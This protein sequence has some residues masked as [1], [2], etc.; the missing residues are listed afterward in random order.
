LSY[1]SSITMLSNIQ[2]K[3]SYNLINKTRSPSQISYYPNLFE[4]NMSNNQIKSMINIPKMPV[5]SIP[6]T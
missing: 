2:I 1:G 3:E 5:N 4:I 6:N